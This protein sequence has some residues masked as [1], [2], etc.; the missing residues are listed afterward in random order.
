M[1]DSDMEAVCEVIGLAF[2]DNPNALVIGRRD[3]A[4]AERMMRIGV[5]IAK[6]SRKWNRVLVALKAS[7]IVGVLNAV[8]W[9]NCQMER[10]EG[11][12]RACDDSSDG[13][14]AAEGVQDDGG[15]DEARP[16]ETPLAF[17]A[18]RRSPRVP[19]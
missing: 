16:P 4:K 13:L 9:P 5:R 17:R 19:R 1:C 18:D 12:D 15:L 2:A 10:R 14:W 11:P 3:R 8:K 7:R 6:L